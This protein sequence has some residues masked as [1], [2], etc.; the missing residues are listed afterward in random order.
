[1][2]T[3]YWGVWLLDA[4]GGSRW[5]QNHKGNPRSFEED[6]AKAMAA[7]ISR[8]GASGRCEARELP[9]ELADWRS[10]STISP[11]VLVAHF[12]THSRGEA[13]FHRDYVKRLYELAGH[14][15]SGE[16]LPLYITMRSIIV[17]P[18]VASARLHMRG[19]R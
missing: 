11:E 16:A 7:T 3:D 6:H 12:E 13:R 19:G 1:M 4:E 15:M 2:R 9:L 17:D 10:T 14:T 8:S 5:M 18:L